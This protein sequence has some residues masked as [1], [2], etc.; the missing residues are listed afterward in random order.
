MPA[1]AVT[2]ATAPGS[3]RAVGKHRQAAH[4][5]ARTTPP[6]IAALITRPAAHRGQRVAAV[7]Q[8]SDDRGQT[9]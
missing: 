8:G 6:A 3:R 4:A 5:D 2:T 7:E 1:K 9:R